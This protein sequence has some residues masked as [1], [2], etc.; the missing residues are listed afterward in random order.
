MDPRIKL[1][2]E[3]QG[4][5]LKAAGDA[6][7]AVRCFRL[8]SLAS[9]H[10]RRLYDQRLSDEGITMQQGI[11]LSIVRAHGRPTLGEVARSMATSHQNAKQVAL[12]VARKGFIVIVD[13]EEDRR[14][15]RLVATKAGQRGWD[16]RN[17]EDFAAVGHWFAALSG[18]ERRQLAATLVKLIRHLD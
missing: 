9:Q 11:L 2:A 16:H 3:L 18:G 10:L 14:A 5:E 6:A 13:D 4:D 17:A 1:A 15:K 12:A 7:D 8:I